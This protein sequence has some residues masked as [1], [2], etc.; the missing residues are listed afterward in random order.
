M[1]ISVGKPDD[2]YFDIA[3]GW[4]DNCFDVNLEVLCNPQSTKIDSN[5][6]VKV[7]VWLS[8]A[9]HQ[10]NG[11]HMVHI[12]WNAAECTDCF[13]LEPTQISFNSENF[14]EQQTL[15]ITRVEN[16]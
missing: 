16:N 4:T 15:T 11:N 9:P 7:Q 12:R 10:I 3:E 5:E 13:T 6:S 14:H 8:T 2:K 1:I